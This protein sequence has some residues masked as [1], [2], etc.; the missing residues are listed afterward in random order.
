MIRNVTHSLR[1]VGGRDGTCSKPAF[2]QVISRSSLSQT[3]CGWKWQ[4]WASTR[5]T[6]RD[7]D[8][9]SQRLMSV[10]HTFYPTRNSVI[11]KESLGEVPAGR[12]IF[13]DHQQQLLRGDSTPDLHSH[14]RTRTHV[15]SVFSSASRAWSI[16][17]S[18]HN[19]FRNLYVFAILTLE[20][21]V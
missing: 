12:F 10:G 2:L 17:L 11:H 20:Q 8:S 21:V 18:S 5:D 3:H 15:Y 6:T 7:R 1:M 9:S 4:P 19:Y 16:V 14:A 13:T